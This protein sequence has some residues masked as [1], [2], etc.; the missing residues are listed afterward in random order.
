MGLTFGGNVMGFGTFGFSNFE[1]IIE[2]RVR[3]E[4]LWH[5]TSLL[6]YNKTG[7]ID[8]KTKWL[9]W[10]YIKEHR[11]VDIISDTWHLREFVDKVQYLRYFDISSL[12]I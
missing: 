6:C 2:Y 11:Y 4:F 1:P 10:A 12:M 9:C 7:D 5:P 3:K 8:L